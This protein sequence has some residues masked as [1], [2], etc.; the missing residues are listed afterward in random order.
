ML[1]YNSTYQ[2][3]ADRLA[4]E[5][6]IW[7]FAH[8]VGH[9]H[10]P[11]GPISPLSEPQEWLAFIPLHD[12]SFPRNEGFPFVIL[13]NEQHEEMTNELPYNFDIINATSRTDT[14]S[15]A[16][17]LFREY[18]RKVQQNDFANDQE[19]NDII[20]LVHAANGVNCYPIP[21]T[22]IYIYL[23]AAQRLHRRLIVLPYPDGKQLHLIDEQGHTLDTQEYY[24]QLV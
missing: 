1:R 4:Q 6:N 10:G 11:A 9:Y 23:Q 19:R 12:D 3:R 2:Q 21:R 5:E 22:D 14:L 24:L 17:R 16:R 18:E 13:I 20:A 15:Q 8:Y 7:A